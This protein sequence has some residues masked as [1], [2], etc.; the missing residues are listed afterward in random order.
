VTKAKAK[1]IVA[2]KIGAHGKWS[3][4]LRIDPRTG[5]QYYEVESIRSAHRPVRWVDAGNGAIFKAFSMLAHQ[6]DLGVKGDRKDVDTTF[7]P[8]T[9]LYELISGDSRQKTLD[10]LNR[11]SG[12]VVMTDADDTWDFV[13][14]LRSPSQPA[15]V[16]AQYYAGVVDDFYQDIFGR[17]SIDGEG[18]QIV[19]RVHYSNRYCN[20]FWNGEV[21][22]YGDGDGRT[23]LPLSGGLDVDGHELTHGV[24]EFTSGLIYEDEPGALNERSAT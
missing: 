8:T 18:M 2:G 9:G 23:C 13:R 10:M 11:T 17:N 21:M 12:G 14:G 4:E 15:G 22:T 1:S 5:R 3:N 16:D 6:D 19:S 7:N 20:A 24:T